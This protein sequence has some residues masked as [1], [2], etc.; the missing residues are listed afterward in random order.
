MFGG[1]TTGATGLGAATGAAA[2]GAGALAAA[3]T[4]GL[5]GAAAGL[6]GAEAFTTGVF[7]VWP[8]CSRRARFSLSRSSSCRRSS[9]SSP[10]SSSDQSKRV[11]H[12]AEKRGL[13]ALAPA[14]AAA[15]CRPEADVTSP[16]STTTL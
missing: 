13:P 5:A 1:G 3:G 4:A 7:F 16:I 6:A 2:A 10:R 9:A 11:F 15:E 8:D 14:M 12:S